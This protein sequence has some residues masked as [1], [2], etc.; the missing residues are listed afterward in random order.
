MMLYM[1]TIG[2]MLCLAPATYGAPANAPTGVLAQGTGT[3][4]SKTQSV[5]N[6][7]PG[8][9]SRIC[10]TCVTATLSNQDTRARN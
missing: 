1:Y 7:C 3:S 4:E 9:G 8:K 5:K 6:S 2:L 10:K